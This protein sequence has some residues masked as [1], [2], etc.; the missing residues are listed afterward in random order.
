MCPQG[1]LF[2]KK[3]VRR[4]WRRFS[5]NRLTGLKHFTLKHFFCWFL[6]FLSARSDQ[7]FILFTHLAEKM[8]KKD[9]YQ[10][11]IR[12]IRRMFLTGHP[13]LKVVRR[14]MGEISP[15]HRKKLVETFIINQLLVGT[16]KRQEFS[17][18]PGGF[19]PPGFAVISPTMKCNLNCYG[20]YSA[21]HSKKEEL[22]YELFSSALDQQKKMGMHFSVISGGEPFVYPYL[23]DI[24]KA[25]SD[26]AFLVYTNGSLLN[27]KNV[28]KLA[29][30]GNVL[31]CIS[32]EGFEEETDERRGKGHYKTVMHAFDLLREAR[33]LYGFSA[34]Q[35]RRN[36]DILTSDRYMD[37]FI[38]KGCILG[39]YFHYMPV[40]RSPA[41]ELLPTPEQRN[42]LRERIIY[43]RKTKPILLGDFHNDGPLVGGCIAA[44]RKYFHVNSKGDIEP[45]VFFQF[46]KH[47]LA[48]STLK[49]AL[50]SPF[51]QSI[52]QGQNSNDNLLRPCTIIDQPEISRQAVKCHDAQPSHEEADQIF[53]NLRKAVDD[54]S[55][56]YGKIADD[57]WKSM[58]KTRAERLIREEEEFEKTG[59]IS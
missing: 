4:V 58:P 29:E 40:G 56:A 49:E 24:F 54:Y 16:D 44:G 1:G 59:K 38:E 22:S 48:T 15:H 45:C 9:Y 21:L 35:T 47:N 52:R 28:E 18:S 25:H 10:R 14:I 11:E 7:T 53:T 32:V 43:F 26:V 27:E 34:T 19:Y 13:S 2:L 39:W 5:M 3:I 23:F 33:L 42:F 17:Q 6:Q 12:H 30:L 57:A 51:F 46:S 20:C 37:I 41:M 8:A 31:P 55:T 36:S 50:Q